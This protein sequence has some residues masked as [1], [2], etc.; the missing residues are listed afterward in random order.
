MDRPRKETNKQEQISDLAFNLNGWASQI[1]G[2][3]FRDHLSEI[4]RLK[5]RG[6]STMPYKV[7][8]D[9]HQRPGKPRDSLE[10]TKAEND[11]IDSDNPEITFTYIVVGFIPRDVPSHLDVSKQYT[12]KQKPVGVDRPADEDILTPTP[13]PHV[14]VTKEEST[15]ATN[16]AGGPRKAFK[17]W[18]LLNPTRGL[19]TPFGTSAPQVFYLPRFRN[20]TTQKNN[21]SANWN[22][23]IMEVVTRSISTTATAITPKQERYKRARDLAIP[24][25]EPQQSFINEVLALTTGFAASKEPWMLQELKETLALAQEDFAYRPP[26]ENE[27]MYT[28]VECEQKFTLDE[29]MQMKQELIRIWP[30]LNCIT[31]QSILQLNQGLTER[32]P[33]ILIEYHLLRGFLMEGHFRLT[34]SKDGG[35]NRWNSL[36]DLVED[37]YSNVKRITPPVVSMPSIMGYGDKLLLKAIKNKLQEIVDAGRKMDTDLKKSAGDMTGTD[38]P[39]HIW[40]RFSESMDIDVAKMAF[41]QVTRWVVAEIQQK[42][43][44]LEKKV[45]DILNLLD[46]LKLDQE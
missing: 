38:L 39:V 45:Q 16:A 36:R 44:A 10:K 22:K 9:R 31:E 2:G 46:K 15:S 18:V 8:L 35:R 5:A 29:A 11:E 30:E 6:V 13:D 43:E 4:I 25:V 42:H 19:C 1:P 27:A 37:V 41:L 17:L 7:E 28:F 3:M 14:V 21:R 33:F 40:E 34:E 24:V 12:G 26:P 20:E 32:E 23:K